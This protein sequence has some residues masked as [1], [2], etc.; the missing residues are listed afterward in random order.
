[1]PAR[2]QWNTVKPVLKDVLTILMQNDI[3]DA[4][5]L[6]GGT[7]L[8]LQ[9]G[10]RMSDYIDLFTDH[11]YDSIDFEA[12]DDFLRRAFGYVSDIQKGAVGFGVSYIVGHNNVHAVKVDLF[13]TDPFFK[14]ALH[15]GPYRLASIEEVVAMKID[16][17]Q[18]KARKKDFWDLDELLD[19]YSPDEMIGFHSQRYPFNHDDKLIRQNFTDFSQADEDFTPKCLRGKHWE[20]IKLD[21]VRRFAGD[22]LR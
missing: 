10:H 15:F 6:V 1:M 3:F 20:I 22:T 5:R 11:P 9:I 7:S 16:I 21:F 19:Y 18:R 17:V 12:I 8:S 13:Y 2:L 14:P 4:F